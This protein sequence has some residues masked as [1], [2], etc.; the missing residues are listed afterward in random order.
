MDDGLIIKH[1]L[2][3]YKIKIYQI[4]KCDNSIKIKFNTLNNNLIRLL[5][6]ERRKIKENNLYEENGLDNDL[7]NC[8][9]IK[10]NLSIKE[11]LSKRDVI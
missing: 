6:K 2:V 8:E 10:L 5:D 11:L 9:L 3:L 4:L 1:P 7:I